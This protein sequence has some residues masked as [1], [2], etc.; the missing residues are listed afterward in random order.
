M[1]FEIS[2]KVQII[3]WRKNVCKKIK[4]PPVKPI[5]TKKLIKIIDLM[6]FDFERQKGNHGIF[7]KEGHLEKPCVKI[8][9][10]EA[11]VWLILDCIDKMGITTEQ[12]FKK[13][14]E[15]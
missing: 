1:Y 12:Y 5:K 9:K 3:K 10:K 4:L 14:D 11:P 15:I 6:G 2:L 8:K 7:G 13:L